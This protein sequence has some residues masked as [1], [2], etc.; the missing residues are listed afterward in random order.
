MLPARIERHE[1][2][3]LGFQRLHRSAAARTV[4][5]PHDR[6][7]QIVRHAFGVHLLLEDRRVGRTAAHGEVVAAD[8]DGASVD[9][10]TAHDEVRR[11]G[12]DEIAVVV[13]RRAPGERADL[14]KRVRVEQRVDAFPNGQLSLGAVLGDLL[15]ATHATSQLR[16]PRELL[17]LRLPAVVGHYSGRLPVAALV[18]P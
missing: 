7:A 11:R 3:A 13:V 10:P 6:D 16:T 5:E 1:G 9:A 2:A 8:H 14:V 17:E 4:D 15:V 18:V 12:V